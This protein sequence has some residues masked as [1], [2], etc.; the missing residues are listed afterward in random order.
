[1]TC[2]LLFVCSVNLWFCLI[3][4]LKNEEKIWPLHL[5]K[6]QESASSPYSLLAN[7]DKLVV[8]NNDSEA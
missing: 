8:L 1:M 7:K 3:L 6:L 2:L 5:K 4:T